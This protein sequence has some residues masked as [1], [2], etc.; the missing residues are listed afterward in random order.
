MLSPDEIKQLKKKVIWDDT[1]VQPLFKALSDPNRCRILRLLIKSGK[2]VFSVSDIAA[3]L[4]V[5]I[6]T[7]SEHLSILSDGGALR[8]KKVKQ[9]VSYEIRDDDPLIKSIISIIKSGKH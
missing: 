7:A 9:Q 2:R 4:S 6:P 8:R 3:L 1:K 5:S